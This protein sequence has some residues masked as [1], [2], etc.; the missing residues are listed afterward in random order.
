MKKYFTTIISILIFKNICSSDIK[1]E[2]EELSNLTSKHLNSFDMTSIEKV[3]PH[4][5]IDLNYDS[6][7]EY[8]SHQTVSERFFRRLSSKPEVRNIIDQFKK[9]E[10]GIISSPPICLDNLSSRTRILLF[11]ELTTFAPKST[12]TIFFVFHECEFSF[13]FQKTLRQPGSAI[14][15]KI[16]RYEDVYQV[17]DIYTLDYQ[18]QI[19]IKLWEA[20]SSKKPYHPEIPYPNIA[21]DG[22]ILNLEL[23]NILLDFEVARRLQGDT[24]TEKSNNYYKKLE[25]IVSKWRDLKKEAEKKDENLEKK[26]NS[27]EILANSEYQSI[28]ARWNP[29]AGFINKIIENE[30]IYEKEAKESSDVRCSDYTEKDK[31]RYIRDDRNLLDELPIATAITGIFKIS[32]DSQNLI[33]LKDFFH[34]TGSDRGYRHGELNAFEGRPNGGYRKKAIHTVLVKANKKQQKTKE[35][36]HQDY[37]NIFGGVSESEG[38]SYD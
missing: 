8:K 32:T 7:T 31:M 35:Q 34:A 36:I 16:D 13:A 22:K 30:A 17:L 5:E 24:K 38:E 23:L 27:E 28:R 11:R 1:I 21:K 19:A 3:L 25:I 6:D 33:A 14:L 20:R 12:S 4:E 2:N 29:V 26:I 18:Q 37:L 15:S 9:G 10:I